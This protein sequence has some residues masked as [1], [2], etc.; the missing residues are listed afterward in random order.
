MSL[1][2]TK[3]DRQDIIDDYL[4]KTGRNIYVPSEFVD[5]LRDNPDHKVYNLFFGA[6]DEEMA[7]KHRESMARQFVTGLRIKINISEIPEPSK[8]ENLKVEVVDV[9][10]LISPINNRA[11]G[12]GYVSV[13][14]KETD[15]MTE[16]ALQALRDLK[17]WQKRYLGT[18]SLLNVDVSEIDR[19]L[20]E[21]KAKTFKEEAA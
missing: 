20:E 3:Q 16:L 10:S 18:C 13:D 2:F 7:D 12:G 15:T 17:S 6:S 8:I 1:R 21:L 11:N 14:V 5:W 9:P 19:I 4:N